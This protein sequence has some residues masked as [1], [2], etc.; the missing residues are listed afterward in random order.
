[1][2]EYTEATFTRHGI[3]WGC[4]VL[5]ER[6]TRYDD[7]CID[8]QELAI[9]SVDSADEFDDLLQ[10][11]GFPSWFAAA[12]LTPRT[13]LAAGIRVTLEHALHAETMEH[14]Y[15]LAQSGVI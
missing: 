10:S 9:M 6:A 11:G 5:R 8:I 7:G 3:E 1:M 14:A 15:D 12:H 4:L 2:S 13:V